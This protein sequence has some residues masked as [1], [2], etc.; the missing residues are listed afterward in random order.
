MYK[1][2]V[3]NATNS[4]SNYY[5]E[6]IQALLLGL[7]S[8]SSNPDKKCRKADALAIYDNNG[9]YIKTLYNPTV[10]DVLVGKS[11]MVELLFTDSSSDSY[12]ALGIKLY[13]RNIKDPQQS[14]YYYE[15]IKM[16]MGSG[17][18]KSPADTL[19]IHVRIGFPQFDSVN[20][21]S[22]MMENFVYALL[23]ILGDGYDIYDVP[24][25]KWRL[26]DENLVPQETFD[27]NGRTAVSGTDPNTGLPYL[28]VQ[29]QD[30]VTVS[31]NYV[32]YGLILDRY[33][34]GGYAIYWL[35]GQSISSGTHTFTMV[36]VQE[37]HYNGTQGFSSKY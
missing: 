31:K 33:Y 13:G 25:N 21:S 5:A 29:F 17:I 4:C 37:Y 27:A 18:A 32:S 8:D 9:N 34:Y 10:N 14:S 16:Q 28:G 19:K 23:G 36:I 22:G 2:V 3:V 7:C 35:G 11:H 15:L 30:T 6:T 26:T 20:P 24:F 1:S 12:N